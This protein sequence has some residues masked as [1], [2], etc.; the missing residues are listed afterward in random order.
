VNSDSDMVP[1]AQEGYG[2]KDLC[3]IEGNQQP[4]YERYSSACKYD[5]VDNL[6][7][8]NVPLQPEIT[9]NDDVCIE[10]IL[11]GLGDASDGWYHPSS[12]PHYERSQPSLPLRKR[13]NDVHVPSQE[14]E[15]S[16]PPSP[17]NH[18]LSVRS[19]V[20]THD[21]S[22]FKKRKLSPPRS[23]DDEPRLV[24]SSDERE[25]VYG[26]YDG[27]VEFDSHKHKAKKVRHNKKVV[28]VE[29]ITSNGE[30]TGNNEEEGGVCGKTSKPRQRKEYFYSKNSKTIFRWTCC[31]SQAK[32]HP[33]F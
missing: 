2:K 31:G 15:I 5:C 28:V 29:S 3:L 26:L 10:E 24:E 4:I 18:S 23:P 11:V 16:P 13:Y 32:D 21:I 22:S 17:F 33:D 12:L 8:Y 20:P 6:S 14:D 9:R 19:F 1:F 27:E 7:G 25:V 30:A